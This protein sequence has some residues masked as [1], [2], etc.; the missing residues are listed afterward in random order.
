MSAASSARAV[1]LL[2]IGCMC[3]QM[4][5]AAAAQL[6]E[7]GPAATVTV[8]ANTTSIDDAEET[9]QA[10]GAAETSIGDAEET[11]QA[12]GA[13]ETNITSTGDIEETLQDSVDETYDVAIASTTLHRRRRKQ[14]YGAPK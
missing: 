12:T 7:A 13:A 10:T 4:W 2:L 5:G 3:I 14:G 9:L 11:L 1:L 8:L 6:E